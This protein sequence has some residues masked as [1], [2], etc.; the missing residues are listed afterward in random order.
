[1]LVFTLEKKGGR[2]AFYYQYQ[3]TDHFILEYHTPEKAPCISIEKINDQLTFFALSNDTH[4]SDLL[5]KS[6]RAYVTEHRF[7]HQL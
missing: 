7:F 6:L 5:L 2:M 1:M 4:L 3:Y